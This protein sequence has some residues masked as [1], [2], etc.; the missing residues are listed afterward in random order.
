MSDCCST[1]VNQV[2][3]MRRD[4]IKARQ[5]PNELNQLPVAVIGGGPV[6]MAAAAH[7][8]V[9]GEPF[10]L[11]EAGNEIAG[12]I[13]NWSHVRLFSP[14]QYNIDKAAKSLL[15]ASGWTA[16]NDDVLPTGGELIE[17]YL[18]PVSQLV[19][20]QPHIHYNAK[21]IAIS[22]KGLSKVKTLGRDKLPFV[23]H[24]EVNGDR[25]TFEAKA[26][27]DASGTWSQPNPANSEGVWTS[28]E[29]ALSDQITYGIPDVTGKHKDQFKGKRVL[30]VGSGH[31]AINSLLDLERLKE[32]APETEI[33]WIIRKA[34][35]RDVYGGQENDSLQERGTLGIRI[36]KMVEN[37][38][39]EVYTSFNIDTFSKNENTISVEGHQ[40]GK[41]ARIDGIQEII[42]NTGSRPDLD[43]LREVRTDIESSIESVHSLAPLIDPNI[44][45]CGTVRPHGEK[46]LRQP[47]HNLYIVGA[48]SYGRAPT[49]LM[50]T[51]YEQVRSVVAALTGD[52]EAATKVELDLPETGV[53]STGNLLNS[54]NVV[55]GKTAEC[56]GGAVLNEK[57]VSVSAPTNS[58]CCS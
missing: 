43:F 27:I 46:E 22:R 34:N 36:E 21:V 40:Y 48:K 23:I 56:C 15:E 57:R 11:F 13:A 42:S 28:D 30:V 5:L 33:V 32:E 25:K 18:R 37:G 20:I 16:P 14:W 10:I 50:A 1:N 53:C 45:S 2:T 54:S 55:V 35:L 29:L 39:V 7:L 3:F 31:S 17:Q 41:I 52:W 38:N 47:E 58:S 44:H 19:Q 24:V 4:E 51:G 9:K 26:I 6:G 8:V 12:N 49:S